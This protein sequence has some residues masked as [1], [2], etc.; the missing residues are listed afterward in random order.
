MHF[1]TGK[2]VLMKDLKEFT[3]RGFKDKYIKIYKKLP[4]TECQGCGLCCNDSPTTDYAGFLFVY[5]YFIDDTIFNNED[6]IK[7]F[8]NAFR[9]NILALIRNDTPCAF[10]DDNKR[11]MIYE[12]APLACKRWGLQ[13]REEYERDLSMDHKRNAEYKEFFA[14][15]GIDI[16]EEVANFILPYCEKVKI[17][18]NPYNINHR[19]FDKIVLDDLSRARRYYGNK[20]AEDWSLCTYLIYYVFGKSLLDEK[21]SII[22][23]YQAG[24][25]QAIEEFIEKIDFNKYL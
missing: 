10:L 21:L 15:R 16:P 24:N 5:D 14:L 19:D 25:L 2:E 6:R 4:K 7:I 1:A 18:Q 13:S 22:K 9:E 12:R 11:C 20:S 8:K 23:N 3:K 17:I